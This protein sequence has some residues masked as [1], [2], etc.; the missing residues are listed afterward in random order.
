M[1][2]YRIDLSELQSLILAG[3]LQGV[4]VHCGALQEGC[5]PTVHH[6]NC[7]ECQ[8]RTVYGVQIVLDRKWF[9]SEN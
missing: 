7:D 6:I 2:C 3:G 5:T 8:K 1:P 9:I 4:C